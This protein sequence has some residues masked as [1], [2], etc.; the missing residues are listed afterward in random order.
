MHVRNT[1]QH[2]RDQKGTKKKN[3]VITRDDAFRLIEYEIQV[4][5]EL[6]LESETNEV[7]GAHS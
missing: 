5:M 4:R 2:P 3:P 1:R 7:M 6:I